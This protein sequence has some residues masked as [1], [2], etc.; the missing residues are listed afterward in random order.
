MEYFNDA[1]DHAEGHCRQTLR[2]VHAECKRLELFEISLFI[3]TQ[4]QYCCIVNSSADHQMH[5]EPENCGYGRESNPT[6]SAIAAAA[7][8]IELQTIHMIYW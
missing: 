5:K 7:L 4:S 2:L 8:T 1:Q 3:Y 6:S